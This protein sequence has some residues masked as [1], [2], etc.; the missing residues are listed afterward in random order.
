ML[1][2]AQSIAAMEKRGCP[3]CGGR[4]SE[5][6]FQQSFQSLDGIG[7][8]DGYDLVVCQG[9]GMTFADHIPA[10]AA[11]DEYYREL[12]KYAYEHRAGKESPDDEWRLRQVANTLQSLIPS[13]SARLLEIGCA[14]GSLIGMLKAAGYQNVFGLDPSPNCAESA[15]SQ[16]GVSVFTGSIF[17]PPLAQ[18]GYDFLVLLGVLEHIRDVSLA[19]Q[20]LRWL[21]AASGHV[22]VEVPDATNLIAECDAPFQEFSTEH[23]NFFSPATLRYLMEAAEFQCIEAKSVVRPG[24][25]GKLS[26]TVCGFFV[27]SNVRRTSFPRDFEG[28]AGLRRYISQGRE[29]DADLKRT[30]DTVVSRHRNLIV[31]G[32]GTLTQ[33]LLASGAL[34]L[35]QIV[36][37]VDSNP[38][39][40]NQQLQGIPVVGPEALKNFPD[41][42]LISSYAF[43]QE[44]ADQVRGLRLPNDLIL[45]Y[46]ADSDARERSNLNGG[47]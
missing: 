42:I 3:I 30:I 7:L 6:L 18:Q 15:L 2:T 29:M 26:G 12:S 24:R 28:E 32:V 45:L 33:R 5:L 9:C 46:A 17:A 14:N 41:P 16:Y 27:N 21:L 39:Y 11:F 35:A 4:S 37:F 1:K 25:T 47:Q 40:Q 38:K 43:Q 31:W 19:V 36:A 10:Q 20:T 22:Y 8:L 13:R 34:S 44:I 23:I